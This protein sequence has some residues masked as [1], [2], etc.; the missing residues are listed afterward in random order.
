MN[1][2]NGDDAPQNQ[3]LCSPG[4]ISDWNVKLT[5][6]LHLMPRFRMSAAVQSLPDVPLRD[7]HGDTFTFQQY[8]WRVPKRKL[9]QKR[10]LSSSCLTLCNNPKFSEW[11]ILLHLT[12]AV[13]FLF[14]FYFLNCCQ[15]QFKLDD[16]WENFSWRFTRVFAL[17]TSLIFWIFTG[18][19]NCWNKISWGV[20][21]THVIWR[22]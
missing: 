20:L 6:H 5:K 12:L 2:H 15:Y 11:M 16:S 9:Q 7:M 3:G 8:F 21:N 13:F 10:L 22:C 1:Q 18:V 17:T 4:R 19:K 14:F